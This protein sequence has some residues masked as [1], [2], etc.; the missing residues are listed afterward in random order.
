MNSVNNLS[1]LNNINKPVNL[2]GVENIKGNDV[3]KPSFEE[4][5]ENS[6]KDVN[7][8]Q[9]ESDRQSTLLATGQAE[10]VHDVTI[11]ASKAKISLDLTMAVRNKVV[12]AYKEIMRMQV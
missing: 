6:I 5:L 11:A 12:E 10:N 9:I 4:F 7:N 8:L 1:N 3:D 2:P